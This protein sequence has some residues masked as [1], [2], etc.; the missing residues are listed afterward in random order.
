[1]DGVLAREQARRLRARLRG[2]PDSQRV[3]V[4]LAY[5]G[6]LTPAEIADHLGLPLGAVEER[7]RM[8]I[9]GL[10]EA[11]EQTST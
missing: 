5:Y 8:A 2:L 3:V 1:M 9:E 10:R 7:L 4:V 6:E 11:W